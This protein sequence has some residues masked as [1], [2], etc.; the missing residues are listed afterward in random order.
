MDY[1][2]NATFSWTKD[3]LSRLPASIKA[4]G[5]KLS[6]TNLNERDQG[7][8][9]LIVSDQFGSDNIEFVVK[10]NKKQR[11]PSVNAVIE[12]ALF[13]L[14]VKE[15]TTIEVQPGTTF[16]LNCQIS[17]VIFVTYWLYEL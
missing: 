1:F 8:Y 11:P 3:G 13:T 14:V 17:H 16:T 9:K 5:A 7:K 2:G 4:D 15:N 10:V 6:G 12:S